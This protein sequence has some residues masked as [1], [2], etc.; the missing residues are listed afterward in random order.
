MP[1]IREEDVPKLEEILSQALD[2]YESQP[3]EM[4]SELKQ[5]GDADANFGDLV[6]FVG[7]HLIE[8]VS[9]ESSPPTV[10]HSPSFD[11]E[12]VR[13]RHYSDPEAVFSALRSGDVIVLRASWLLKRAGYCLE[14]SSR[15]V[16]VGGQDGRQ[17]RFRGPPGL[18]RQNASRVVEMPTRV[19][20]LRGAAQPLPRRQT[21]QL[22]HP[23]AVMAVPELERL[24]E[25]FVH[26][27]RTPQRT[28]KCIRAD[29]VQ[30]KASTAEEDGAAAL[31]IISISQ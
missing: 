1:R 27:V 19:W 14:D 22:E 4:M 29:G 8:R 24:Q 26:K 31:P 13:A 12:I 11:A 18:M 10:E 30:P 5:N 21:L 20:R 9:S 17:G 2:S 15:T 3:A 16:D 7:K 28:S 25:I 23:E 6:Q